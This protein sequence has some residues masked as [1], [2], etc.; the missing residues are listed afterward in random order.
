MFRAIFDSRFKTIERSPAEIILRH[1]YLGGEIGLDGRRYCMSEKGD[2]C[3]ENFEEVD[4]IIQEKIVPL[5]ITLRDFLLMC[6]RVLPKDLLEY[7]IESSIQARASADP[8][9]GSLLERAS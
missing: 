2:L 1:L 8:Q 4:G 5:R 6:R 3:V 7:S 9:S